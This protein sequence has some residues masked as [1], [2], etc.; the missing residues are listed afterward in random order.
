MPKKKA[1]FYAL[2][3]AIFM[4]II[5]VFLVLTAGFFYSTAHKT[6]ATDTNPYITASGTQLF[7]NGQPFQFTGVNAFNLG[8]YPGGNAG[9]GSYVADLDA[10]FS[11]LRTNSPVRMWAFQGTI[12]TNPTTKQL[13]WTGLDR[14]VN[15]AQKNGKKLILVLG[16][17]A[18]HCDDGH[19]KDKAWYQ[20]GYKQVTNDYGN[21]L[22]PLP[23]LDYVKQVVT[24]YKD[25]SAIAMWEPINEPNAAD[26]LSGKGYDCYSHL[27]CPDEPAAATAMKTF[28][29]SVGGAIKAIDTHHLVSSGAIGDGQCGTVFED[30]KVVHQSSGIDVGSYHDY[31][32]DDQALPGDQWN[33][34]QKRIDQMKLLN[35]PLIIGEVGMLASSNGVGCMNLTTR[36]DKMKNKMDGQFAAG[37]AGIMPWSLSGGA[38]AGCN[39]DVV[40]NDPL[41]SLLQSYPVSMSTVISAPVGTPFPTPTPVVVDT[42]PPTAPT[43]LTASNLTPYQVTL[44]WSGATDNVKIDRYEVYRDYSYITAVWGTTYTNINLLPGKNY[45]YYIK[46]RDSAGNSSGTSKELKVN[47][48]TL[49]PTPTPTPVPTP[50]P[51]P[52]PDTQPPTAPT[53]VTA[54]KVTAT[55]VTLTWSGATDNV[56]IDRYEVYRDYSYVTAVWGTSYT[57][58]GLTPG[59]T[60]TFYLK[61]R[62]A[63]GNSSGTSVMLKVTT[64]L[65]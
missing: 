29:D 25:S 13:D 28:F 40:A 48:P 55:S 45:T 59:K 16:D 21:G 6:L 27:A 5:A 51:T 19:W 44:N 22:T 64:L 46:T 60:Y 4:S 42:Q 63:A 8:T 14:V 43:T 11:Q 17:Q 39:Y 33:G 65:Q 31:Q 52:T 41:L 47:T 37:V 58:S 35:K 62:D 20:G 49:T 12:T 36:R 24:R 30:Y 50:T 7:L 32:H 3:C 18:G 1:R 9:C 56:K 54:S 53:T 34:L 61:T 26:C 38:S 23:Y 10:F 2:H 15:A 57:N